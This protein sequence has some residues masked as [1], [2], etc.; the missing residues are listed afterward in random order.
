[1]RVIAF[2]HDED[3]IRKILTHLNLWDFKRKPPARAHAPTID[4]FPI[5]DEPPGPSV[6]AYNIDPEY[7]LE[8]YF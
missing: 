4:G 8:A 6:D 1:M 5:Y 7:P 3:V 2:V